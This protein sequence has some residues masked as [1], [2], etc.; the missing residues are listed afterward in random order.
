L[1]TSFLLAAGT[2][3]S[4][5]ARG[6]R[7]VLEAYKDANEETKSSFSS[8]LHDLILLTMEDTNAEVLQAICPDM[9]ELREYVSSE[10]IVL[11]LEYVLRSQAESISAEALS[12]YVSILEIHVTDDDKRTGRIGKLFFPFLIFTKTHCKR[13]ASLWKLI[14][15]SRFGEDVLLKNCGRLFPQ[16]DWKILKG[17]TETL[18]AYNEALISTMACELLYLFR[19]RAD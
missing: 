12:A 15:R 4:S 3:P 13:T 9:L 1:E 5:R 6:I 8:R 19:I 14:Q 2:E 17:S 7:M 16:L 10:E 18:A 11:K